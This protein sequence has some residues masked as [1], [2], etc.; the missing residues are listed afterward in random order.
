MFPFSIKSAL[1]L[2]PSREI[3]TQDTVRY[4]QAP[5]VHTGI[6]VFDNA[7]NPAVSAHLAP[8]PGAGVTPLRVYTEIAAYIWLAGLIVMA[9]YFFITSALL[10]RRVR[11]AV[12]RE[13]GIFES[14]AVPSPFVFGFI[15]PKIYMPVGMDPNSREM[16]AAHERAHIKRRDYLIK[17]LAFFILSVYW[18]NPVMWLA[19]VLLCRDIELA[20]DERVLAELGPECKKPYSEA[21]LTAV[22]FHRSVAACPV[23]FGEGKLKARVKNVLSWKKPVIW[24]TLASLMV[25]AVLAVC[26]LTDPRRDGSDISGRYVLTSPVNID[27]GGDFAIILRPDGTMQYS[28]GY[29]SSVIGEGHWDLGEDK[30]TVREVR[31]DTRRERTFFFDVSDGKLLF[32]AERSGRFTYVRL[33]DGAVF[34]KDDKSVESA[35]GPEGYYTYANVPSGEVMPFYIR[36]DYG[37]TF[38]YYETSLSGSRGEGLWLYKDGVVTMR[39]A[40]STGD[41]PDEFR[42]RFD[43]ETLAYMA[44]ESS[45]FSLE[46]PDGALFYRATDEKVYRPTGKY[47]HKDGR[48]RTDLTLTVNADLLRTADVTYTTSGGKQATS[49]GTWDN[50]GRKTLRL[51]C[52][53]GVYSFELIDGGLEYSAAEEGLPFMNIEDGASLVRVQDEKAPEVTAPYRSEGDR[54]ALEVLTDGSGTGRITDTESGATLWEGEGLESYALWNPY[55]DGTVLLRQKGGF[56]AVDIENGKSYAVTIKEDPAAALAAYGAGWYGSDWLLLR[57]ATDLAVYTMGDEYAKKDELINE[58]FDKTMSADGAEADALGSALATAFDWNEDFFIVMMCIETDEISDRVAEL[59]A[60]EKSFGDT[61]EFR[62]R[63]EEHLSTDIGQAAMKIL[64]AL[65]AMEMPAGR[66]ELTTGAGKSYG[67]DFFQKAAQAADGNEWGMTLAAAYDQDTEWF[68][69]VMGEQEEDVQKTVAARLV[70]A[71]AAGDFEAFRAQ[72]EGHYAYNNPAGLALARILY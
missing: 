2:I 68:L 52:D 67:G 62:R 40:V 8:S 22:A 36:L 19:Y 50:T 26:F 11:D 20:C 14:P 29:A 18:F 42:F 23:A 64:R 71:K 24:I 13:D 58:L 60:Y 1:S 70:A 57:T 49:H 44:D 59:L 9:A 10:R 53:G 35:L 12:R 39:E 38:V 4:A 33:Q 5:T 46:I 66:Y 34:E 7:V 43:G 3:L 47:E 61:Q 15:R 55:D 41:D 56:V 45:K 30:L 69:R 32:D 72:I 37:G 54:Y 28:E 21:L 63:L 27:L 16:V 17:P 25:C 51:S 48:G 6:Q 65:D 31:E